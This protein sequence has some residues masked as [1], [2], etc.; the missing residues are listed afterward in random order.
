[1]EGRLIFSN[2]AWSSGHLEACGCRAWQ[3]CWHL[4]AHQHLRPSS[5]VLAC[6][7][8]LGSQ[9]RCNTQL[10]QWPLV[11]QGPQM[12]VPGGETANKVRS[13]Q[14]CPQNPT[15][16]C[17]FCCCC[18]FV[19]CFFYFVPLESDCF[20]IAIPVLILSICH[21]LSLPL[22]SSPLLSLSTPPSSIY[23]FRPG[24]ELILN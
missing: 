11:L 13:L 16:T 18:C 2:S 12:S 8:R 4:Q 7:P 10:G 24:L 3:T 15:S 9:C 21:S 23:L 1:M 19:F 14:F 20:I 17:T 5:A 22:V 6:S